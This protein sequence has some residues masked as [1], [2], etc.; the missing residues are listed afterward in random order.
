MDRTTQAR[1]AREF[2]TRHREG[3]IIVLPN[4]FDVATARLIAG[5]RPV[6]IGT[7]SAAMAAIAGY[8]DGEFIDAAQMLDA[9]ARVVD[10]VISE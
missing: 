3:P 2:G 5:L 4:A 8:P 6:A 9:I 10:A 1:L 7:T